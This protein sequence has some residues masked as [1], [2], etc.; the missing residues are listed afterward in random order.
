[1][2]SLHTVLGPRDA[3]VLLVEEVGPVSRSLSVLDVSV[4]FS[5][6]GLPF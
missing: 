2:S 6:D 3:F 4:C 5:H 1:M